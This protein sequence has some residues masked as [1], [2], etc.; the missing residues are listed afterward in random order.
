MAL[1]PFYVAQ[2]FKNSHQ[3]GVVFL[4][5][6]G[7]TEWNRE[8]RVM[9]RHP[10]A[11]SAEGRT[12]AEAAAEFARDL[13]L[14][15]IVRSPLVR[16]LESAGII[17]NLSGRDAIQMVEDNRLAEVEYG[18]WE[19]KTFSELMQD[20]VYRH[21]REHPM[22]TATPGGETIGLAQARGIAAVEET[23]AARPGQRILF[24]SHGD[25]IRTVLCHFMRLDLAHFRRLRIDNATFS[26]FEIADN[27]AEVKF[28]NLMPDPARA[29]V[30]P[31]RV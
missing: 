10:V 28:I 25:I 2:K 16:A 31:F 12:P 7:E 24:V 6:H 22:T 1:G 4:M 30:P 26:A 19:G 8:G 13:K 27:F 21:Y 17:A 14:D 3:R 20:D 29:F 18:R 5:R 15:F 9:G 11:L 23:M